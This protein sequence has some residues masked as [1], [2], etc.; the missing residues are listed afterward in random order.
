MTRQ[1]TAPTPKV[2]RLNIVAPIAKGGTGGDNTADAATQLGA[3]NSATIGV[4]GGPAKVQAGGTVDPV[5]YPASFPKGPT[6]DGPADFFVSG[7]HTLTISN[8]DVSSDASYTVSATAGTISRT[9][10]TITYTA[11]STIQTVTLNIGGRVLTINTLAVKPVQP[12]IVSPTTGAINQPEQVAITANAFQ[13]PS[14]TP[15]HQFSDWEVATDLDFVNIVASSF[16]DAI[17]KTTWTPGGLAVN[18]T[19]HV[20]VRYKDTTQGYSRWSNSVSF[21]TKPTF[22]ASVEEGKLVESPRT[23]S[24]L[25]GRSVAIDSTGTRIAIGVTGSDDSITDA[26]CVYVFVRNTSTNVWSQEQKLKATSQV[27]SSSFGW[28]CD[29]DVNATRL[30]IGAPFETHSSQT[31][32][33]AAYIFVRNTTTN[34]WSQESRIVS[35][36]SIAQMQFGYSV[37]ISGDSTRAVVGGNNASAGAIGQVNIYLRTGSSWANERLYYDPE[38]STTKIFGWSVRIDHS[39]SRVFAGHKFAAGGTANG[40]GA[41][42]ILTRVGTIWSQEAALSPTDGDSNGFFGVSVDCNGTSDTVVVGCSSL[43]HNGGNYGAAYVYTRSGVTWTFQAKLIAT[44]RVASMGFGTSVAISNSGSTVAVGAGTD[45]NNSRTNNGAAY[46]F[47]RSGSVWTEQAKLVPSDVSNTD[48]NNA[49][50]GNLN[51]IALAADSSRFVAGANNQ[52]SSGTAGCGAA[53]IFA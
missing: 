48:N 42:Y 21:T 47:R 6:L 3:I 27:S 34:V 33:G 39:G 16:N 29:F 41:M 46:I 10:A 5:N 13:L 53:Y 23:S 1:L 12:S 38:N 43:V 51:G 49:Q 8:Y 9:G 20:R 2:R 24:N 19:Y 28:A 22:V 35:G 40:Y 52:A 15:S 26:G 36:N 30:V 32:A 4:A 25:F 37:S 18:T 14:G 17:N 11:P 31:N 7:V 50:L 45:S 44:V